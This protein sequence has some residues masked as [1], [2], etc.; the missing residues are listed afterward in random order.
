LS[1]LVDTGIVTETATLFIMKS[2]LEQEQEK[3]IRGRGGKFKISV[4]KWK[5]PNFKYV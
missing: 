4:E 5:F 3:L 1:E 2:F